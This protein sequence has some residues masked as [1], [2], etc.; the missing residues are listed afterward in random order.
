MKTSKLIRKAKKYL[1]DGKSIWKESTEKFICFALE[2]VEN[3]PHFQVCAVQELI[4]Q[5]IGHCRDLEQWLAYKLKC[6]VFELPS[7]QVQAHR[8]AWME[9]LAQEFEA[10]GD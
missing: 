1:W 7:E 9:M 8:L 3:V 6:G 4:A 2:Q 10:K 5:R